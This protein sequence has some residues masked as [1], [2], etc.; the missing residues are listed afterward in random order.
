[1]IKYLLR[2]RDVARLAL[3]RFER[4]ILQRSGVGKTHLPRMGAELVHFVQVF[5][6]AHGALLTA[7]SIIAFIVR[8]DLEHRRGD[9]RTA[10]PLAASL[11]GVCSV[12]LQPLGIRLYNC[13]TL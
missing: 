12:A 10:R 4:R 9:F 13:R 2:R 11:T 1:M 5:G 8:C 7:I 3:P 6:G